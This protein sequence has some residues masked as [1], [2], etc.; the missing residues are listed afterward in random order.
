MVFSALMAID[1]SRT[2]ALKKLTATFAHLKMSQREPMMA[3]SHRKIAQKELAAAELGPAVYRFAA[4][5]RNGI[6]LLCVSVYR[7]PN[8]L[9][10]FSA[11]L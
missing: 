5:A 2:I 10:L 6:F 7:E 9:E 11:Y 8:H 3:V 4:K 1:L